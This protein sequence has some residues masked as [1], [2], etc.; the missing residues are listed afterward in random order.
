M[1]REERKART[2]V[3]VSRNQRRG[4]MERFEFCYVDT[5]DHLMVSMTAEGRVESRIKKDKQKNGD[6]RD[7]ATARVVA[8]L[9]ME[10]W[11]L[12]NGV[13]DIRPVLFFQ[14]KLVA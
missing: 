10:G 2:K 11:H 9:G 3:R 8:K 1:K 13:G 12:V 7:D 6:T 5:L 14:R 4:H